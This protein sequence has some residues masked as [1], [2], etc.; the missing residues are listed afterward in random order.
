M[1]KPKQVKPA[2]LSDTKMIDK[3][4]IKIAKILHTDE[5]IVLTKKFPDHDENWY[6]LMASAIYNRVMDKI[7]LCVQKDDLEFL[8]KRLDNIEQ[9]L[10]EV[11]KQ[12]KYLWQTL[13][14]VFPKK[15]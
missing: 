6:Y 15:E 10:K 2:E 5:H 12:Q 8:F 1:S 7:D 11:S 3:A 13:E 14:E 9:E 4:D